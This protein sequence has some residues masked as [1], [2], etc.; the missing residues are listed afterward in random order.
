MRTAS[1]VRANIS[2]PTAVGQTLAAHPTSGPGDGGGLSS[3]DFVVVD[4]SDM[5]S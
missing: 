2:P 5:A 4:S 1:S 3:F